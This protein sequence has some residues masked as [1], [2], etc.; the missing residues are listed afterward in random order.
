MELLLSLKVGVVFKDCVVHSLLYIMAH[1]G[2]QYIKEL[3]Q[4]IKLTS[5]NFSY[6]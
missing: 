2:S 3:F 6:N 1:R 5:R 4:E